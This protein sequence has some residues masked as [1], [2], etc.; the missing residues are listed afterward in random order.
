MHPTSPFSWCPE[1]V[2]SQMNG[3]LRNIP[4][5]QAKMIYFYLTSKC[6][7]PPLLLSIGML[8]TQI[9]AIICHCLSEEI[10]TWRAVHY[11]TSCYISLYN[12][13]MVSPLHGAPQLSYRNMNCKISVAVMQKKV[14]LRCCCIVTEITPL[15]SKKAFISQKNTVQLSTTT[16]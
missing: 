5:W 7:P 12:L 16:F 14:A 3:S 1:R 8:S 10:G 13:R 15:Q 6:L 9:I 11:T 2:S 4:H